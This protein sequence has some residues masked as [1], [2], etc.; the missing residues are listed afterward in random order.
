[1]LM[2]F[3]EKARAVWQLARPFT[4][5]PPALGVLSSAAVAVGANRHSRGADYS[6]GEV[7]DELNGWAQ[8]YTGDPTRTVS[9]SVTLGVLAA[10]ALNVYSNALNQLCDLEIDKRA[11]PER[12]LVRGTISKGAGVATALAGLIAGLVW[13]MG[14]R[15]PQFDPEFLYCALGAALLTTA[16]SLPPVRTKRWGL[17]ANLTVASARGM[18]LKVAGWTCVVPAF[19]PFDP[20]PWLIGGVFFVFTLGAVTTK[21]F[22]DA[23]HDEACGV[24]SLPVAWGFK[25]AAYFTAVC[26]SVPWLALP[27]MGANGWL[28]A[29]LASF[30]ILGGVL[31]LLGAFTGWLLVRDPQRLGNERNHPAWTMMYVLMMCAQAGLALVYLL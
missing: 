27:A 14:A 2:A 7:V 5:L 24:R 23:A 29:P 16:Y 12:P 28:H 4:C 3:K 1:M 31:F 13:A 26:L 21:D 19:R 22:S 15:L 10:V 6:I 30:A 11:K 8:N 20:E 17:A 9:A 25:R 18:L